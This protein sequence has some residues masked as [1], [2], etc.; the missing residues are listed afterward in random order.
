MTEWVTEHGRGMTE[1]LH[2]DCEL[3]CWLLRE[4][5]VPL[6]VLVVGREQ[7]VGRIVE[8]LSWYCPQPLCDW[9]AGGDASALPDRGTLLLQ[10]VSAL[11][12]TEQQA[13]FEWLLGRGE[14]V[15]IVARSEESPYA[16]VKA[17]LFAEDLFYRLN[18]ITI[19]ADERTEGTGVR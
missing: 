19:E 4:G 18:V 2:A 14:G 16:R 9:S 10:D 12:P 5:T 3:A 17:G 15:T 7:T 8:V 1:R 6:H 13:L 11:T